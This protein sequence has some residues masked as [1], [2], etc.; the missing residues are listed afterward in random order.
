VDERIQAED[1][2]ASCERACDGAETGAHTTEMSRWETQSSVTV[3]APLSGGS[4]PQV[5]AL[6]DEMAADVAGNRLVPLGRLP[7]VHFARFFLTD[8]VV[9]HSGRN[10]PAHLVY[11]SDVDGTADAHLERL[12]EVVG[13]GLDAL[14][15]QSAG[16]PP[17]RPAHRAERL[18]Y[19]RRYLVTSGVTYVNTIGRT[20]SQIQREAE[21]RDAI[22]DF[23][24]RARPELPSKDAGRVRAAVINF[25]TGEPRLHWAL[26]AA[27]PPPLAY[28]LREGALFVGPLLV[29]LVLLPILLPLTLV[30]LLVLRVHESRD[31]APPVRV[32]PKHLT[33]LRALEDH[34]AQNQFTALGFVKPGWFRGMTA[35]AVLQLIG[36]G[37]RHIFNNGSLAGVKTIHFAR[38]V[39]LDDR[40]RIVFCS[41][42]DGS[43]ESYMDDFIDKVAWGLNAV[44]SNGLGYPPTQWLI[45]G[46]ARNEEA[47]KGFLRAHQLP[48]QVWFTAYDQVTA[49]NIA[50]NARIRAGL[51][52]EMSELRAQEWLRL[53]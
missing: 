37:S 34:A 8:S 53:L 11:M 30:W 31:P 45:F 41:N 10:I 32:D 1:G 43:T 36:F 27:P 17:S 13:D 12:V 35:R 21:L 38:W 42:Y 15:G 25:V 51:S 19:L 24:D 26:S 46:G 33:R 28:R 44:F 48:T 2:R 50:N 6:L 5:H 47:F 20:V 4:V 18:A 3:V 49:L 52:G 9:D 23:L 29:A 16:Y 40:V 14:F 22:E 39:P 7:G